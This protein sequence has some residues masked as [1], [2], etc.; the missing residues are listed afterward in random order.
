MDHSTQGGQETGPEFRIPL[1]FF[2]GGG[3]L[4]HSPGH[5][6]EDIQELLGVAPSCFVFPSWSCP[7]LSEV[8]LDDLSI[9]TVFT[10]G[11]SWTQV[12]G[13]GVA[14]TPHVRH[15]RSGSEVE[16]AC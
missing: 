14:F 10:G 12:E 16:H 9:F 4:P 2:W 7:W 11:D 6:L 8:S 5:R 15:T 3:R 1:F 13:K